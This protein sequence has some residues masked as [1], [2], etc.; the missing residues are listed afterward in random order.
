MEDLNKY[1]D[2]PI[3]TLDKVRSKTQE[4]IN[5]KE[6]Y[7]QNRRNIKVLNALESSDKDKLTEAY[8]S[9]IDS[10]NEVIDIIVDSKNLIFQFKMIKQSLDMNTSLGI[11][12]SKQVDYFINLLYDLISMMSDERSRLDRI[13]RY[14]E[15]TFSYYKEF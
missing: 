12:Q 7:L 4:I 5:R 11:Q 2:K 3:S 9:S 10:N 1:M 14:N 8:K 15:K 13:V 6:D